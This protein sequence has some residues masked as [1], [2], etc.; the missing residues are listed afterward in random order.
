MINWLGAVISLLCTLAT[1]RLLHG[2][3]PSLH[4]PLAFFVVRHLRSMQLA[5]SGRTRMTCRGAAR[6]VR[7]DQSWQCDLSY[8]ALAHGLDPITCLSMAQSG[9]PDHVDVPCGVLSVPN[10]GERSSSDQVERAT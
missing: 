9:D 10:G 3:M 1:T 2:E 5:G 6:C 8:L 7:H 4:L